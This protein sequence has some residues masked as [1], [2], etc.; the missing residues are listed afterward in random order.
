[1]S[2]LSDDTRKKIEGLIPRYPRKQAVTL[3][4]LHMVQDE[5]RC[6]PPA[7]MREI[8]DLLDLH[9]SE[10]ND[11]ASFY[12]IFRSERDPLGKVRLWVCRSLSCML[13][14]GDEL[15]Q[16]IAD[17]LGVA[18]GGTTA[19]GKI[20]LEFAECL[21]ACEGAPCVLIDDVHRMNITPDK[22]DALLAELR[23]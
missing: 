21:G 12:G 22:I 15:L 2:T 20:T 7:A 23:K 13:R 4:A 17:K 3:P 10:V 14:G 1:M 19:D 16:T 18:P 9:P 8:A 11:T 6:V 5:R